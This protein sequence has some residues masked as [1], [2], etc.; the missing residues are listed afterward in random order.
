MDFFK[1]IK[2]VKKKKKIKQ[3][4]NT[5]HNLFKKKDCLILT[6]GP[7]LSEYS[8]EQVKEFAKNK[9]VICIK[10]AVLEYEDICHFHVINPTRYREYNIKKRIFRIFQGN[11]DVVTDM[12]LEEDRPFTLPNQLLRKHNYEEY[13]LN[14][15]IKRPWGPGILYETVFYL[16]LHM[17]ITNIYTLGWDL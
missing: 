12:K 9:I 1:K 6:C 7:S 4:I 14:Y 3:Q 8:K 15:K 16:C 5:L 2:K 17:G 10:E 11:Q 13:M